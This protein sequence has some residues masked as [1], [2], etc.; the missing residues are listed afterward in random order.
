MGLFD[1]FRLCGSLTP[2]LWCRAV[3]LLASLRVSRIPAILAGLG[4]FDKSPPSGGF[5]L[6]LVS[7]LQAC[8]VLV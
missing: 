7:G 2:G 3:S 8:Q 4:A 1:S 6:S 5:P